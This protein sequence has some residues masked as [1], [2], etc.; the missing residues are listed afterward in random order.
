MFN[1]IYSV[2]QRIS[3]AR[4]LLLGLVA[5][6]IALV[7]VTVI[8]M[9]SNTMA[10]LNSPG[11]LMT[12]L[13]Q[14]LMVAR[15]M[16][17]TWETQAVAKDFGMHRRPESLMK[18]YGK[19]AA[20][21]TELDT[22]CEEMAD[23][24]WLAT[25]CKTLSRLIRLEISEQ[26]MG[27]SQ[28]AAQGLAEAA[29][30]AAKGPA[31]NYAPQIES[32]SD[33]ILK[34]IAAASEVRADL[35]AKKIER[36][37]QVVVASILLDGF[38]IISL[39]TSLF[40]AARDSRA[41]EA[42]EKERNNELV[43]TIEDSAKKGKQILAIARLG[44]YLQLCNEIAEAA[45]FVSREVPA[46]LEAPS[47]SLYIKD[48]RSHLVL[49]SHWGDS[50]CHDQVI[51]PT[52]CWAL[53][54]GQVHSQ[55]S[56]EGPELCEHLRQDTRD[57]NGLCIPLASHGEILGLLYVGLAHAASNEWFF[58]AVADQ[59][60]LTLG[61]IRLRE[62]LRQQS[63]R[64]SLTTL[65]NRRFIDHTLQQY[66]LAHERINHD[67]RS[68]FSVLMM[69]VDHFKRFN[70]KYGH[71]AGDTVLRDVGR[72][73]ESRIR[74][75]DVAG[76]F[77][78][79][80]FVVLLPDTDSVAALTVAE[81]LRV[82]VMEVSAG[83]TDRSFG[84]ITVS[85]GVYTVEGRSSQTPAEILRLADMALYEAKHGGRNRVSVAQSLAGRT[86]SHEA[87]VPKDLTYTEDGPSAEAA[88][89]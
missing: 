57:K 55:P 35:H 87:E 74:Q 45:E 46:L 80:E 11:P 12:S 67:T 59:I 33:E 25:H 16:S 79:E 72:V 50:I 84:N 23:D 40:K 21:S 82:G 1:V 73:I 8:W 49:A 70:D 2:R 64:D 62:T 24:A 28:W 30:P 18:Y 37:Q 54:K 41:R 9:F 22:M 15:V 19:A 26:S 10:M 6:L 66:L 14:E 83:D 60:S 13:R 20:L 34:H 3:S 63:F 52:D 56:G 58:R 61:N 68:P 7:A 51:R 69:D 65:Y 85:I 77:G 89:L 86:R 88:T 38:L 32:V 39:L 5:T 78:G 71:D 44:Q 36:A 31:A 53:R 43:S 27:M 81:S 29:T 4:L 47:G 48:S 17:L 76:R 75:T 42:K